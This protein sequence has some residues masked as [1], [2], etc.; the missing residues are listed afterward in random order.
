M[1]ADNNTTYESAIAAINEAKECISRGEFG[2]SVQHLD[3]SLA[4]TQTRDGLLL[5]TT[6]QILNGEPTKA[7]ADYRSLR[8]LEEV[9]SGSGV[10]NV[11]DALHSHTSPSVWRVA[12]RVAAAMLLFACLGTIGFLGIK[13]ASASRTISHVTREKA[14]VTK[15]LNA[16]KSRYKFVTEANTLMDSA[17]ISTAAIFTS[18]LDPL[19]PEASIPTGTVKV[20]V[21]NQYLPVVLSWKLGDE[22]LFDEA[23]AVGDHK[24]LDLPAGDAIVLTVRP[25]HTQNWIQPYRISITRGQNTKHFG[26]NVGNTIVT[27]NDGDELNI[28]TAVPS[29]PWNAT[30]VL[31]RDHWVLLTLE[32]PDPQYKV[33]SFIAGVEDPRKHPFPNTM[34][35]WHQVGTEALADELADFIQANRLSKKQEWGKWR[36]RFNTSLALP[37]DSQRLTEVLDGVTTQELAIAIKYGLR[38]LMKNRN[39]SQRTVKELLEEASKLIDS[40]PRLAEQLKEKLNELNIESVNE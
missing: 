20:T 22:N 19:D 35:V 36:G 26:Y 40:N 32:R 30:L 28:Q 24:V 7:W 34:V 25:I 12:A 14:T 29:P 6:M 27:L 5:R 38:R 39:N 9:A 37:F 4:F 3:R 31:I 15:N 21:D 2:D 18:A 11:H 13:N 17:G 33:D 10:M 16:L 23:V 1:P 8:R